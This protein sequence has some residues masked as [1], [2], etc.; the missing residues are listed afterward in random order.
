[1]TGAYVV[2]S[3]V[4][5]GCVIGG[6]VWQSASRRQAG[7][8]L[9]MLGMCASRPPAAPTAVR[10]L[11][12]RGA[13]GLTAQA[14]RSLLQVK[15]GAARQSWDAAQEYSP[16]SNNSEARCRAAARP[17]ACQRLCA[18]THRAASISR[19]LAPRCAALRGPRAASAASSSHRPPP[20]PCLCPP[21][22]ALPSP[23]LPAGRW[24]AA[25]R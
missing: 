22:C 7:R 20:P 14:L 10:F 6:W 25:G 11:A 8:L 15:V 3:C 16:R 23:P 12:V 18:A 13:M 24:L 5:G 2:G 17:L 19:V 9:G 21:T 4:M 1:M